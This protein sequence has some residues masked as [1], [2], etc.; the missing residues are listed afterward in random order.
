MTRNSKHPATTEMQL[1][2]VWRHG[3][4]WPCCGQF[5][6]VL[7]LQA[8]THLNLLNVFGSLLRSF[9]GSQPLSL[10]CQTG[11][12]CVRL[13]TLQNYRRHSRALM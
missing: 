13:T 7:L 6:R 2:R 12:G 5:C 1:T 8:S 11:R 10:S 3:C 9:R 4:N